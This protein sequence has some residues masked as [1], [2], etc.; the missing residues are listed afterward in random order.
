MGRHDAEDQWPESV[1]VMS[2]LQDLAPKYHYNH[3]GSFYRSVRCA[4][5]VAAY[6]SLKSAFP[7][8]RLISE[9]RLLRAFDSEWFENVY[10][11]ALAL[12]LAALLVEV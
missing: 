6:L 1:E 3:L 9:L 10:A 4:P 11:I 12:G 5:F 2:R 8:E 7:T